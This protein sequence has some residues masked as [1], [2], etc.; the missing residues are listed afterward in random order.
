MKRK[1]YCCDASRHLYEDYYSR[2][3]GGQMPVFIGS[4]YQHG[5]G[6][7]SM[8]G[9]LFRRFVVP[10]FK[11]QGKKVALNALRMG[12]DVAEDVLG[13]GRG[14][15]ESVKRRVPGGIKSTARSHTSVWIWC[16]E[17]KG[18]FRCK[19]HIC[20]MAFAH[21]MSCE[22]AKSELDLFSVPPN[23]T[24]MEYGNWVE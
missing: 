4:R 16:E 13:S 20:L 17:K 19:Q 9:G 7:G 23:Q 6:L 22:C 8:L 12:M 21:N 14:L 18:T 11:T 1:V 15:K 10:L 3:V 5:H 2:Q 24:S